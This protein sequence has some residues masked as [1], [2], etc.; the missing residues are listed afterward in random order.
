MDKTISIL[1]S[2][3][4]FM[5]CLVQ[6]CKLRWTDKCPTAG[7]RIMPAGVIELLVNPEFFYLQSEAA[8]VGLMWHEMYHLIAGHI[9][10]SYGL[11]PETANVAMD[12]SINQLIPQ[13]FLPKRAILPEFFRH[14][15]NKVFEYYY[16]Q[17]LKRGD[18]AK[19]QQPK[20]YEGGVDDEQNKK[21]LKEQI[22]KALER[23]KEL[24]DKQESLQEDMEKSSKGNKSKDQKSDDKSDQG[25]KQ[26]SKSQESQ[27]QDSD[28]NQD[29]QSEQ[30]GQQESQMSGGQ[31]SGQS[32]SGNSGTPSENQKSIAKSQDKIE[33]KQDELSEKM[34]DNGLK[35]DAETSDDLTDRQK[36]LR[37]RMENLEKDM[38]D[39]SDKQGTG[40]QKEMKGLQDEQQKAQQEIEDA[41]NKLEDI[42]KKQQQRQQQ[43][44]QGQGQQGQGQ[45]QDG[46]G[47]GQGNGQGV[48]QGNGEDESPQVM[49]SHD[50][51]HTSPA[52]PEEQKM[53][54]GNVLSQAI[55]DAERQFGYNSVPM[56]LRQMMEKTMAKPKVNWRTV[57]R[58]Y[59]G[60]CL[61]N[62][63]VYSRKKPNRKFGYLA[64]GKSQKF[65]PKII[66]AADCSGSVA[67]AEYMEFMTE[68]LGIAGE[69]A[70]K[71]EM[72]FFDT[73]VF[74]QKLMLDA[75][76][77]K[78]PP[79]PLSGGTDFQCVIDYANDRKPDL[80]IVLTDGAAPTP[81]KPKYPTLWA[82]CGGRD[83]P[84]LFGKRVLIELE[85]NRQNT[86]I[87]GE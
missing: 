74:D 53:S 42:N 29:G 13:R 51:W 78:I 7:V 26:Q 27:G 58:N 36:D 17:H 77:K 46:Q 28:K 35:D 55:A 4:P 76:M 38:K 30:D 73:K 10:G 81:T 33:D 72:I 47:S 2:Y 71:V 31:G 66:V 49:D 5:A 9:E 83:N 8:R 64:P 65:G 23:Q 70:E 62:D 19:Y 32:S 37:K 1:L 54:L 68:F 16:N 44:Q 22:K 67:D 56:E 85:S 15:K 3:Q 41:L 79:R 43:K 45:P 24:Q 11:D 34:Q 12:E 59:Y 48:G 86:K 75:N 82:I 25:E 21:D 52:S 6:R 20:K 61:V 63:Q 84:A 60:R 80:L 39:S 14:E 57:V 69:I 18:A 50:M 40:Q 87:L